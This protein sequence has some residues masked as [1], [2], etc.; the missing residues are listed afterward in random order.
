MV[1]ITDLKTAVQVEEEA[2]ADPE[3]RRE[4][5]RTALANAV[6]IRV[7][8]YRARHRL[9]QTQLAR[10][11]GMH[12]SAIARLEAGDHEPSLSTLARLA[13]QLGI[14]FDIL[15]TPDAVETHTFDEVPGSAGADDLDGAPAQADD[16]V[17]DLICRQWGSMEAA[18]EFIREIAEALGWPEDFKYQTIKTYIEGPPGWQRE[19][20]RRA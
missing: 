5:D 11:L 3:V 8:G 10:Q 9:S 20:S 15:I 12:Q 13:R 1:K 2:R 14:A 16:P 6:A 18:P 17:V 19:R 4:L 7:I